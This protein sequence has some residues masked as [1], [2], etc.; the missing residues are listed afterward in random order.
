MPTKARDRAFDHRQAA[1]FD[2]PF[3]T[4][5]PRRVPDPA[6]TSTK[7]VDMPELSAPEPER[8]EPFRRRGNRRN[9][10]RRAHARHRR[11]RKDL[12]RNAC[13]SPAAR[14][15]PTALTAEVSMSY[16]RM[17]RLGVALAV[18]GIATFADPRHR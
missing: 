12:R 1:E 15:L 10:R 13:A 4:P 7:D 9:F 17:R 5:A 11:F 3:R 16:A 18:A 2:E 8:P 14:R 6:A